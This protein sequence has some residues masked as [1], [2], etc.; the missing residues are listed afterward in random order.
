LIARE[1]ASRLTDG[2]MRAE[3]IARCQGFLSD[4]SILEEARIARG[5]DGVSAMHDVT[6]GGLATAVRELSIAGRHRVHIDMDHIPV[7]PETRKISAMLDIDPLGLIGSGSLLICCRPAACDK[8]IHQITQAGI[9][10]TDIGEVL[11]PG[12]GIAAR[13]GG[14]E[15]SWPDFVVDEIARLFEA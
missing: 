15:V 4:I 13:R 8:L 6:E 1:F 3:E 12:E 5:N 7:F 2:R 10:V 14:Q 11:A 9:A